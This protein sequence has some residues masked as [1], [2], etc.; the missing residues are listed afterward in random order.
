M[1]NNHPPG[2]FDFF[3][4]GVTDTLNYSMVTEI[5]PVLNENGQ[6]VLA[7]DQS[8]GPDKPSWFYIAADTLSFY[9]PFISGAHRMTNGNTFINE[10]ARG[11]FFEVT[12]ENEIVWEYLIPF[13]G[14]IHKP[15]GDPISP[16][17][18]T[19]SAFRSTFIPSDHPGLEGKGLEPLD[20]QPEHFIMPPPPPKDEDK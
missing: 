12:P 4:M 9:S 10:G 5:T 19:F 7:A 3:K 8:F 2:D 14:N 1:F 15:N 20:P 13:R 11:R 18:M 16:M 17:F 6:Y